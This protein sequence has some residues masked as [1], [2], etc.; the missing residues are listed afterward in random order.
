MRKSLEDAELAWANAEVRRL[1]DVATAYAKRT[2]SLEGRAPDGV[3]WYDTSPRGSN[4][5]L[6]HGTFA[7][8]AASGFNL[9]GKPTESD[10]HTTAVGS[11]S[12]GSEAPIAWAYPFLGG[13]NELATSLTLTEPTVT[14]ASSSIDQPPTVPPP[15][16]VPK[17][18]Q[19]AKADGATLKW[20]SCAFPWWGNDGHNGDGNGH[21][22]PH[23]G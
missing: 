16:P 15:T 5:S 12:A 13:A 22:N 19:S 17:T 10:V 20:R 18:A 14:Q 8:F 3:S 23:P 6:R 9:F 7:N 4:T 21:T 11:T 1:Q 2:P